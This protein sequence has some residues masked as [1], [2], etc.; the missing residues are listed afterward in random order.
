MRILIVDDEPLA[1][2]RLIQLMSGREDV[3]V[4]GEAGTGSDALAMANALQPDLLLLD[5]EMP[6]MSGL[7]VLRALPRGGA[8]AIVFVTAYQDHAVAAF[9]LRATDFVVKP[10]RAER[11]QAALDQASADLAARTAETRLAIL[12]ERFA[13]LESEALAAA[14]AGVWVQI[15]SERRRLAVEDIRWLEAERDFVRIH[16][17]A[18]PH[19]A[20][21]LLG[22]IEETLP[23]DR[24]LRVHRS[25]IVNLRRVRAVVRGRFSAPALEL[26]DGHL[27]PIGRKYR[28]AV[29]AALELRRPPGPASP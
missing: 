11:L 28:D 24:F 4:V 21:T 27:V 12:Q 14:D 3:A 10:V 15:G 2:R 23:Q 25:A 22:R 26:D 6:G 8:P 18:G 19:L 20:S 17:E 9:E 5:I 16:T 1:R 13:R 29:S 7:D